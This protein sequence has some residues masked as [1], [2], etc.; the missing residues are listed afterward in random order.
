MTETDETLGN[1]TG[2]KQC[3]DLGIPSQNERGNRLDMPTIKTRRHKPIISREVFCKSAGVFMILSL[4][5][6][7]LTGCSYGGGKSPDKIALAQG[8]SIMS[9][10]E[11]KDCDGLV[12]MFSTYAKDSFDLEKEV[13]D[14]INF[15]DGTVVSYGDV[16]RSSMS[17][18]FLG[19]GR[20]R[21]VYDILIKD[22]K[23]DS[24]KQYEIL[25]VFY[26]SDDQND[27]YNGL[28]AIRVADQAEYTDENG[29][30]PDGV[31]IVG[32]WDFDI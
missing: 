31:K 27:S 8:D 11:K 7:F 1:C 21:N 20:Y 19:Y 32:D 29:Y 18:H 14:L 16:S 9:Y 5:I 24:S 15:I 23:T 22:V 17:G 26:I 2:K 28:I 6:S 10:I 3:I 30:S 25:Y 13:A 12:D 4:F